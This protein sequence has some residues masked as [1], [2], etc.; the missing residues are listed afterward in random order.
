MTETPDFAEQYRRF[1]QLPPGAIAAMRRV[2]EPDELRETPGLYRLF[3]GVRP[4]DQQV[5]TAFVQPWCQK[6][7]GEKSLA[8]LCAE[9]ISEA[10]IIQIARAGF[11]GD[12]I[13]FRRLVIQL[14]PAL[15]WL[16]VA[17]PVWYWGPTTKRRL[18]EDYY[19]A[20]HKLEKGA[21]P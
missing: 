6:A 14:Q 16:E 10:R 12:L 5:R 8:A 11:P 18:V 7:S 3:A 4:S 9:K 13:A 2:G 1:N 19:I 20:L 17:R 15:G 21:N